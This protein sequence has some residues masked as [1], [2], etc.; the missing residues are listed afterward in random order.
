MALQ[1][2]FVIGG[3]PEIPLR[4]TR[5]FVYAATDGREGVPDM[6]QFK[7]TAN[8]TG[9]ITVSPGV[10]VCKNATPGSLG[11]SYTIRNSPD[12]PLTLAIPPTTFFTR[13]DLIYVYLTDPDESGS[14][15]VGQ[16]AKLGIIT[17]T[18]ATNIHAV[19]GYETVTGYALA[20]FTRDSGQSIVSANQVLDL[21]DIL[22]QQTW[23]KTI[24]HITGYEALATNF[25]H[26]WPSDFAE[27]ITVPDWAYKLTVSFTVTGLYLDVSPGPRSGTTF[28]T[29]EVTS[30][31]GILVLYVS[32]GLNEISTG[33]TN[34]ARQTVVHAGTSSNIVSGF[35]GQ[36]LNIGTLASLGQSGG[37][38]GAVTAQADQ[39][40]IS[41]VLTFS[42]KSPL[43]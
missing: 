22:T 25:L 12:V 6:S 29:L 10:L 24:E 1:Y 17:N 3:I 37:V 42:S 31:T 34:S 18:G 27:T 26:S 9:Q 15:P 14:S 39:L 23:T 32:G 19:P 8:G 30:S 11:E 28:M 36:T 13:T 21:R 4:D 7:V 20:R 38:E 43:D 5:A 35:R 40:N 2:P 33:D 16:V 41:A